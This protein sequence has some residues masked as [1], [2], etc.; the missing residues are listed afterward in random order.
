MVAAGLLAAA[1]VVALAVVALLA[2]E[3]VIDP[4]CLEYGRIKLRVLAQHTAIGQPV[5]VVQRLDEQRDVIGASTKGPVR[6]AVEATLDPDGT[7]FTDE[8]I[9]S[10]SSMLARALPAAFAVIWLTITLFNLWMAGLIVDAG[11]GKVAWRNLSGGIVA[12][13]RATADTSEESLM[14]AMHS[15]VSGGTTRLTAW[16]IRTWRSAWPRSWPPCP[17][18]TGW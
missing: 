4:R 16:G 3:H 8:T 10:L 1:A 5:G 2:Q 12:L 14:R 13:H 17:T 9:A 6:D 11:W 15:F 7:I 18:P